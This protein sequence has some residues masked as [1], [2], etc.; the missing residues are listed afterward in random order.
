[1]V[2]VTTLARSY[3]RCSGISR[4]HGA[5]FFWSTQLLPRSK[6]RHVHALYALARTADDIVDLP[7][8]AVDQR[9]PALS[10]FSERFF[11]DLDA[12]RSSDPLLGAVVDTVEKFRIDTECFRR[13][14]GSM[15]M[16]LSV[17]SYETWDELLVYMDGSAA[18]IGEMMLPILAPFD[19]A[20]ALGPARDLGLAFQLTNFLR[21]I[22]QD[23][24][25]GREYLP[26]EDLERF[27]VRLSDRRAGPE[28]VALMQ[29]EIARCRSLYHSAADGIGLLPSRSARCI[30]A[31]HD[32]YGLILERIEHL[33]YDVF[34]A[35]ARVPT[36]T[37]LVVTTRQLIG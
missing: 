1:M 28:F 20:A 12:G 9:G 29:F 19:P 16:D 4:R 34:S 37:K 25:R 11:A 23:L 7:G 15:E 33:G 21:D 27:G 18:V 2:S 32:V 13:F 31:A 5:T 22:A 6:Q 14:F 26:Q 8:L 30:R 3:R 17:R 35:R 36:P 10:S 24:D